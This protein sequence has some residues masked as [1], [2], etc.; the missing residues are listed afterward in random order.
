MFG[1]VPKNLW[2]KLI[3]S[4]EQNRITLAT[5]SLL[6]KDNARTFLVDLGCGDKWLDKER[7]IF[8]IENSPESAWGFNPETVTDIILTHLH[9]DHVGGISKWGDDS[10]ATIKPS[11]PK[12]RHYLQAGNLEAAKNSNIRERASYLKENIAALDL[13]ETKLTDG[14]EE[15]YPDIWVHAVYGHTK[16]QQLVEVKED[17]QSNT[18]R[19]IVFA[20]DL[21]PTS[22]HLPLSYHM[23]YDLWTY[24]LIEEK[25]ALLSKAVSTDSIVV[26]QHCPHIAAATISKNER[27]HYSVKTI[28]TI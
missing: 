20:T 19:S 22:Y 28:Q 11:F 15:I 4:D 27:G 17:S 16:A 12:A 14:S 24:K 9:F 10:K 7:S 13:V 18:G 25:E 21:I 5:R 26:F 23:G 6:I 3:P 2:N 1:S 8:G